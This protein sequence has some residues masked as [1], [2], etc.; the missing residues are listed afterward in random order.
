MKGTVSR[1]ENVIDEKN[2]QIREL[3][4][5]KAILEDRLQVIT[6]NMED[7]DQ[8][9]S[10]IERL[11]EEIDKLKTELI[12]LNNDL[13]EEKRS[14]EEKDAKIA[15]FEKDKI[16]TEEYDDRIVGERKRC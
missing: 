4:H 12:S 14:T 1:L 11:S 7:G 8:I 10:E 2:Y 3:Q 15:Q 6:S 16:L 9:Q 5:Q 13:E